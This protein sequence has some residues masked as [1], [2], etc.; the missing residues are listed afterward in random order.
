MTDI[1]TA[2]NGGLVRHTVNSVTPTRVNSIAVIGDSLTLM[3]ANGVSQ[4]SS[5]ITNAF[6]ALGWQAP[7]IQVVGHYG[8]KIADVSGSAPQTSSLQIIDTMRS[9]GFDP[10][11][12]VFALGTNDNFATQPP[13]DSLRQAATQQVVDKVFSGPATDYVIHWIGIGFYGQQR[14]GESTGFDT[15]LQG[16]QTNYPGKFYAHS[17]NNYLSPLRSDPRWDSWWNYPTDNTDYTHNTLA[18][19][20]ELRVPFYSQ[21]VA[22]EAP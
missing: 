1:W 9:G 8:M 16:F 3:N 12:W 15:T 17:Y 22:S 2:Q 7:N 10:R 5:L 6:V 21:T 11:V 20:Q 4:G 18:G 13:W 14:M 19:Y